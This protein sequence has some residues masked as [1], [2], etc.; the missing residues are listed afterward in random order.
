MASS[1]IWFN[2]VIV[3]ALCHQDGAWVFR[4]RLLENVEG[5]LN[6]EDRVQLYHSLMLP[7]KF[8]LPGPLREE[9]AASA[10]VFRSILTRE[11]NEPG[12]P[13]PDFILHRSSNLP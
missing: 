7:F 1:N 11:A 9:A 3:F 13:D 8:C 12:L 10:V 4:G 6:I 5:I 2:I